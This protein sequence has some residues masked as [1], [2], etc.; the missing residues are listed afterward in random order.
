M[1]LAWNPFSNLLKLVFPCHAVLHSSL[2]LPTLVFS[3]V[4]RVLSAL[5]SQV[6]TGDDVSTYSSA[7]SLSA[8]PQAS[9]VETEGL[10]PRSLWAK[11]CTTARTSHTRVLG[12]SLTLSCLLTLISSDNLD[13]KQ[14]R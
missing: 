7:C 9:T 8:C 6:H 13:K 2:T 1:A 3:S 4:I 14:I 5:L 11:M 12:V 10:S